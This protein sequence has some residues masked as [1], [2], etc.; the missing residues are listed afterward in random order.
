MS[1]IFSNVFKDP[2]ELKM[3]LDI[4][5]QSLKNNPTLANDKEYLYFIEIFKSIENHSASPTEEVKGLIGRVQDLEKWVQNVLHPKPKEVVQEQPA[6]NPLIYKR[7]EPITKN[8]ADEPEN[9]FL[10]LSPDEMAFCL[11]NQPPLLDLSASELAFCDNS[12]HNVHLP[13]IGKMESLNTL[14]SN[15]AKGRPAE[16]GLVI[17]AQNYNYF[18]IREDGHCFYRGVATGLLILAKAHPDIANKII[19]RIDTSFPSQGKVL[20][21]YFSR[22]Q[23]KDPLLQINK[24]MLGQLLKTKNE[25]LLS[26]V[27]INSIADI[28]PAIIQII[29][30]NSA[31]NELVKALRELAVAYEKRE[32]KNNPNCHFS[33][34]LN[35][36]IENDPDLKNYLLD[37]GQ[38]NSNSSLTN[39]YLSDMQDMSLEH[40]LHAGEYEI[41]A[42]ERLL[43]V[44]QNILDVETI[45]LS[46]QMKN[47]AYANPKEAPLA[48]LKLIHRINHYD[49]PIAK[50][51]AI[52]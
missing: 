25:L 34:I 12:T 35:N 24:V 10:E 13:L 4:F 46:G 15:Y 27:N 21:K 30:D 51:A 37:R 38:L 47:R 50:V 19:D 7:S 16:K 18:P 11:G 3:N 41:I 6:A 43:G 33:V 2:A 49:L 14:A 42:L 44:Y 48:E 32:L 36:S 40:P 17:L 8:F 31:S 9:D 28:D 23:S 26:P 29:K 5:E 45:G 22:V 1:V 20:Q 39:M 52:D